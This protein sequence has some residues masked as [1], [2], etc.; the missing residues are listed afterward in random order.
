MELLNKYLQAVKPGLPRAER[1]DILAELSADLQMEIDER[2]AE[3]GREL[4]EAE[5]AE[6]LARFG[7]PLVVAGRYQRQTGSFTF[8]RQ[9]IGPELFP[10]YM[11][12]VKWAVGLALAVVVIVGIVLMAVKR[13][14]LVVIE[15]AALFQVVLQFTIQTAIWMGIQNHYTKHP[16]AWNPNRLATK[17][18][19]DGS[20]RSG[21]FNALAN[22]V[23]SL[24]IAPWY[25]SFLANPNTVLGPFRLAPVWHTYW[26]FIAALVI[27]SVAHQSIGLFRP[28]LIKARFIVRIGT[29][30][31][32]LVL[33]ALIIQ[34][35]HWV[36]VIP[37]GTMSEEKRAQIDQA[38]NIWGMWW[39]ILLPI[40]LLVAGQL[41]WSVYKLVRLSRANS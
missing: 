29:S 21:R 35:R 27:A 13:D 31:A 26:P 41:I 28:D 5:E 40:V 36:E 34:A 25:L 6:I 2:Q 20:G 30:A 10:F 1:D 23:V 12:G 3:L 8:G 7:H 18:L 39:S 19:P 14:W 22:I 4:T 16:D 32:G 38:V 15:Q 11:R 24:A 9:L 17:N 37:V 33:L